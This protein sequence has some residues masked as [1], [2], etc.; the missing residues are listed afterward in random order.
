MHVLR[1]A[2]ILY[3]LADKVPSEVAIGKD[4]SWHKTNPT[5]L[6]YIPTASC[7]ASM[8]VLMVVEICHRSWTGRSDHVHRHVNPLSASEAGAYVVTCRTS[9]FRST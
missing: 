5:H 1:S 8:V 6:Y 2:N 3:I 4:L 9:I 7:A